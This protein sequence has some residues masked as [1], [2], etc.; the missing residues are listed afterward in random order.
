MTVYLDSGVSIIVADGGRLLAEGTETQG[1][2]F[3]SPP[4]SSTHW[5]GITIEGSVGSPETRM[6]YVSFEGN[7]KTCL[8]VSAG[9]LYLDHATFDTTK[10][11]YV[12]LDRASF[13]VSHCHFPAATASFE[14]LHGTGRHQGRRPR[15][16][17]ALLLR[18]RD[19]LQRRPGLH[20]RQPGT[21]SAHPSGL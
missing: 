9:T 16:R 18:R 12:S 2:R 19:G 15:H 4:D 13:V 20:R 7:G 17:A 3:A 10:Y 6:A 14:V 8:Q 1:I 5:G 11:R 21:E